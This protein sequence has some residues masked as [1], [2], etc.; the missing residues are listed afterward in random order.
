[1]RGRVT[2]ALIPLS[3]MGPFTPAAHQEVFSCFASGQ[4]A[5]GI[6]IFLGGNS[7]SGIRRD[8][9]KNED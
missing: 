8:E 7:A 2:A 6:I 9:E 5:R 4:I 3:L 1:M